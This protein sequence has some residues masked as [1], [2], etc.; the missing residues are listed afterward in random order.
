MPISY[1]DDE[2][3]ILDFLKEVNGIY[4][5][6]DSH[7][8]IANDKYQESFDTIIDFV[9]KSNKEAKEYFPIFMMGKSSQSLVRKLGLSHSVL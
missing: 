3:E 1:L 7:K 8:A 5:C 9:V 4:I 2:Q 6:G